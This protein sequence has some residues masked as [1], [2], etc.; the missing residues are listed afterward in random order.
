MADRFVIVASP[1]GEVH[2]AV[3]YQYHYYT[4]RPPARSGI[5]FSNGAIHRPN[6]LPS[7]RPTY[8]MICNPRSIQWTCSPQGLS[9][10]KYTCPYLMRAEGVICILTVDYSVS[11]AFMYVE[12]GRSL[13]VTIFTLRGVFPVMAVTS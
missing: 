7:R 2:S 12:P 10:W 8:V 3:M 4:A 9:K 13:P 1:P 6:H 11:G 5:G